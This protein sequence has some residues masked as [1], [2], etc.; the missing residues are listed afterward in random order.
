MEI[1]TVQRTDC[2][3]L[4]LV[5]LLQYPG[6]EWVG[7]NHRKSRQN[8]K[9]RRGSY[10]GPRRRGPSCQDRLLPS[11]TIPLL[12]LPPTSSA[13]SS[14][15]PLHHA[16]WPV[17]IKSRRDLV[18]ATEPSPKRPISSPQSPPRATQATHKFPPQGKGR[19]LQ[20]DP[21]RPPGWL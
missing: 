9:T 16:C 14:A 18:H 2:Y 15:L 7:A 8:K 3:W 19:G 13:S 6:L 17:V 5:L 4:L 20:A 11:R 10:P 12:A 21:S 1:A